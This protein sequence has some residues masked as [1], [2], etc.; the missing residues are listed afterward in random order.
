M[1]R[2]LISRIQL[3]TTQAG[4][5]VVNLYSTDTRLQFPVLTLFDLSAL[6][7]VGIDPNTLGP[8]EP[9][10]HRF[11]AYWTPSDKTNSA[12]N[13]YRDV[14]YLEPLDQPAPANSVDTSATLTELRSIRRLLEI[15]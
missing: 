6:E 15:D 7:T 4:K 12:G 1:E 14:S 2:E 11:Y 13:P 5:P 9:L 10:H 3:S 8:D